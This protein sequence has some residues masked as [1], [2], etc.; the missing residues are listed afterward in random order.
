MNGGRPWAHAEPQN[1]IGA[2][3][4]RA[5]GVRYTSAHRGAQQKTA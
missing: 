4:G 2:A 5:E 1:D 3:E